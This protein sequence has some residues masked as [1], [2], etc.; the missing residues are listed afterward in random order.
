MSVSSKIKEHFPR[1]VIGQGVD[2][3]NNSTS[4]HW[5]YD[6][7]RFT[8]FFLQVQDISLRVKEFPFRFSKFRHIIIVKNIL[9]AV[10]LYKILNH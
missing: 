8:C 3:Y 9:K 1:V 4:V 2:T 5:Y 10:V 7:S 6:I